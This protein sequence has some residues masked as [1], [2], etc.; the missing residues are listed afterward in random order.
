MRHHDP[1]VYNTRRWIHGG[2]Q[3]R[4]QVRE[5]KVSRRLP[6]PI[7]PT[8]ITGLVTWPSDMVIIQ[9]VHHCHSGATAPWDEQTMSP[10]RVIQSR[11]IYVFIWR[12]SSSTHQVVDACQSGAW[13]C[14]ETPEAG[15]GAVIDQPIRVRTSDDQEEDC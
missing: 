9:A 15:H 13:D 12:V 14:L 6:Q 3:R 11:W 2:R 10:A 4:R 7:P 8:S 1:R 5:E